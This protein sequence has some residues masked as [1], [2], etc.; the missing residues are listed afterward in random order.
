VVPLALAIAVAGCIGFTGDPT[1]PPTSSATPTRTPFDFSSFTPFP[2]LGPTPSPCS[3]VG[4][5]GAPSV[6]LDIDASFGDRQ[7][8]TSIVAARR[9]DGTPAT[10]PDTGEPIVQD[11]RAL[12]GGLELPG[13]IVGEDGMAPSVR[14]FL[15]TASLTV[16]G[17]G[18]SDPVAIPVSVDG[19]TFSITFPDRDVAGLLTVELEYADDCYVLTATGIAKVQ[20]GSHQT[21]AGCP[22]QEADLDAYLQGAYDAQRAFLGDIRIE[23]AVEGGDWVW[24]GGS[25]ASDSGTLFGM[26]DRT[27][28]PIHGSP[29]ERLTFHIEGGSAALRDFST[30]FYT[31]SDVLH[32]FDRDIVPVVTRAPSVR[33]DGTV[34]LRLPETPGKYVTFTTFGWETSCLRAGSVANVE[35][36]V[37]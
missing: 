25:F 18:P 1:P 35:V 10:V 27:V 3:D 28:A 8:A 15:V 4:Q 29:G 12:E 7:I 36:D 2:V 14:S 13:R 5:R 31:R 23:T 24:L 30:R 37:E 11:L 19:S 16:D 17:P 21:V 6:H 34:V 33:S 20:V 9:L 22:V 32:E 26:W